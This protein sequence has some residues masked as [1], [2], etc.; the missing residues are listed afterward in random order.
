MS[1][2]EYHEYYHRY[3]SLVSEDRL[4]VD[5]FKEHHI[6]INNF[7]EGISAEKQNY[8]YANGKWS[9]KEVFQHLIDTER[10]FM[11]RCF[12]IARR[13]S[14]SLPG[15]NQEIYNAPS[16]ASKKSMSILLKEYSLNRLNSIN[17]IESLS[18]EDLQ[19]IGKANDSPMSARA[20]AFIIV[21]HELWHLNIL[22]KKYL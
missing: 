17:I 19:F 5:V 7:F 18:E 11:Y 21:G 6:M 3:I 1:T 15:Y 14:T 8:K 22:K 20:A 2:S 9:V 13:D 16:N 12:T 4:L 10:I